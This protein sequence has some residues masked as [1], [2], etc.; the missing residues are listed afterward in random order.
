MTFTIHVLLSLRIER[1]LFRIKPQL[2]WFLS[3]TSLTLYKLSYNCDPPCKPTWNWHLIIFMT[4]RHLFQIKIPFSENIS[5]VHMT[6]LLVY[7]QLLEKSTIVRC[8]HPMFSMFIESLRH[9]TRLQNIFFVLWNW[10]SV[11]SR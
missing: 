9:W 1:F 11:F 4:Q 7:R 10:W 3:I 5:L 2:I 6:T 8:H